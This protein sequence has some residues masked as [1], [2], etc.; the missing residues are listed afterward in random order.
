MKCVLISTYELGHQPFGLASPVTWLFDEGFEVL[1]FD[2]AI[3]EIDH[4]EV[5]KADFIGFFLPMHTAT[6]IAVPIITW[7]RKLNPQAHICAYGLYAP[8]NEKYL[9]TKGV[10][11]IIGG[12]FE[13]EITCV[14]KRLAENDSSY[15]NPRP[16]RCCIPQ[17]TEF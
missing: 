6:R 5:R 10:D 14:V 15:R 4:D 11:T 16:T 3:E 7:A 17:E 1:S 13:E 8:M 12:E 2:L 9:R